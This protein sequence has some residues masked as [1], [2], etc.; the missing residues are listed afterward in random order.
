MLVRQ[1][2]WGLMLLTGRLIPVRN[3]DD[4]NSEKQMQQH[5]TWCDFYVGWHN[6]VT[7]LF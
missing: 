6:R 5:L 7:D 3:D 2:V 1:S 4:D